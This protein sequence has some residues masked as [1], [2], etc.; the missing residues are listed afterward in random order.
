M[1]VW[2]VEKNFAL[3]STYTGHQA[4]VWDCSF[5]ADSAYLVS[6][7][8]DRTAKLWDVKAGVSRK[9]QGCESRKNLSG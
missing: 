9:G 8:S 7:A 2:N 5:S 3:E 4:W 1:K 6:A